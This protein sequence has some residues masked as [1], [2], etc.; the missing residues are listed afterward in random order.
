VKKRAQEG[1]L[2]SIFSIFSISGD[3]IYDLERFSLLWVGR[4]RRKLP[5]PRTLPLPPTSAHCATERCEQ[6]PISVI[7]G[8]HFAGDEIDGHGFHFRCSH[9]PVAPSTVDA[10]KRPPTGRWLQQPTTESSY[11]LDEIAS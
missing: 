4:V 11:P 3:A 6:D 9:G 5:R 2:K 10:H 8:T 1:I 7:I